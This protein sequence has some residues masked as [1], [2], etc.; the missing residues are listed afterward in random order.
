MDE[1]GEGVRSSGGSGGGEERW[2]GGVVVFISG[3]WGGRD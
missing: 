1:K 2:K 3:E